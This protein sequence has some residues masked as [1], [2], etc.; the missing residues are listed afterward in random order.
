MNEIKESHVIGFLNNTVWKEIQ[1]RWL[2]E[3]KIST[4]ELIGAPKESIFDE[5]GHLIQKG[6][7]RLQ[8][9]LG[10]LSELLATPEIILNEIVQGGEIERTEPEE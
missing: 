3:F 10:V 4:Q 9:E 8:G 5:Q 7:E 1:T 2:N 6:V